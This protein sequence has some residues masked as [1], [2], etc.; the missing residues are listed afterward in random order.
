MRFVGLLA[1]CALSTIGCGGCSRSAA[2]GLDA[3]DRDGGR[4]LFDGGDARAPTTA[5]GLYDGSVADEQIPATT[6]EELTA[7][8]KHLLEAIAHDN[9][10]LAADIIF[11]RDGYVA[12]RDAADPGKAWDK[13]VS[14]LFKN[15]V[16]R[17]SKKKGTDKAQFVSLELGHAVVQT[18]PKK[19]V[20]KKPL[21]V[22]KHSK[23]TY[24]IDGKTHRLD[25]TEMTAWRGAW[26]VT[27]LQ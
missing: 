10:D 4:G 15:Q 22:V 24:I 20:W 11:P 16:H 12:A 19:H 18:V 21:W 5:T 2:A 27:R 8:A 17:L 9:P 14:T 7:R 26:Y 13:A 25:I 1:L 23:L 3:G 6:S